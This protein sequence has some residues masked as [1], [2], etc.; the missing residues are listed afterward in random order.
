[1][2][3][4][5]HLLIFALLL[6]TAALQAQGIDD[7]ILYSQTRYEGTARSMAMGGATGAMGGDVTAVC[8]NPAALG[9]YRKTELTFTT[10]F[11]H[12]LAC[13]SYYGTDNN[14]YRLRLSIPNIGFVMYGEGSNYKPLRAIM[15]SVS[16]TRTNDLSYKSDVLGL[17]PNSSRVDAFLQAI[18]GID[19]LFSNGV[20]PGDYLKENY[21]YDLSPAWETY[22]IDRYVNGDGNYYYDSPVPQGNVWQDDVVSARGRSEE[23][24][25]AVAGNFYD[26]LFVGASL[27]LPHLKRVVRHEYKETPF[28][29]DSANFVSWNYKEDLSDTAW[30][31][32]FKAGVIYYPASWIRFGASWHSRSLYVFGEEWSTSI[33]T[34]LYDGQGQPTYRKNL[35]PTLYQ[36]YEFRT[37]HTF[38]GSVAFL[39]DDR[40]MVTA[41]VDYLDYGTCRFNFTGVNDDL[42]ETLKPTLNIRLGT[43]W[44]VQQFFVRGG[45]AYYG[46]YYGFGE[47]FGS[48]KKLG[49]GFGY[50]ISSETSWDF[51]YE[52]AETTVGY[53][54]YRYYVDGENIVET[55]VQRHWRNKLVVTLKVK[56]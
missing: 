44:R 33:S 34:T 3:H 26:K 11:Q 35:S 28:N 10:G 27:G 53:T 20:D 21:P 24:T 39:F 49:L 15:A 14:D 19:A 31:V 16:L 38:T 32:N 9:L 23:L 6:C 46:S 54:P 51:A 55:A 43:E 42:R 1:M 2:K 25:F 41:D 30:G 18:D 5:S 47:R 52:L 56:L 8:I 29:L 50:A 12:S 4:L 13:S 7:A 36:D 37:P 22:L 17:N 40:G 48:M 45:L